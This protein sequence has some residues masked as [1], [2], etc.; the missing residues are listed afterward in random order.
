[1]AFIRDTVQ[2]RVWDILFRRL[3]VRTR[4]WSYLANTGLFSHKEDLDM[5]TNSYVVLLGQGQQDM[6]TIRTYLI[7]YK[8]VMKF[9]FSFSFF[10]ISY[11]SVKY[12]MLD[13]FMASHWPQSAE[14]IKIGQEI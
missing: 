12:E 6:S 5:G 2:T 8:F 11:F 4:S 14:Y 13:W 10:S 9:Y 3:L 7:E 1:M